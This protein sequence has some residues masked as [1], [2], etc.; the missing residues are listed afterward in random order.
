GRGRVLE[1]GLP[2]LRGGRVTTL[3]AGGSGFLGA[4]TNVPGGDGAKASPV[5]WLSPNGTTWQ[6]LGAAQLGLAAGAGRVLDIS[7]AAANGNVIVLAG[8][9]GGVSPGSGGWGAGPG[10]AGPGSG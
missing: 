9:G 10:G 3:T 8:G 7:R 1:P 2:Q 6:G 5:V 4:G